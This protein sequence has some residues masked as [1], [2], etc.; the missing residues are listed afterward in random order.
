MTKL[1]KNLL[2]WKEIGEEGSALFGLVLAMLFFT[3]MGI[4]VVS[5]TANDSTSASGNLNGSE[6]FYVAEGG[7]Q[8]TI[9]N[10]LYGD[11]DWSDNVSPTDEPFGANSIT[12]G[13]GEF[14]VEY[15]NQ[16]GSSVDVRVT[17]RVGQAVRVVQQTVEPGGYP[18][19]A[20][21]NG[22]LSFQNTSGTMT[23]DVGVNGSYNDG[24][25]TIEGEIYEDEDIDIPDVDLAPYAAMTDTTV[26]GN[27]TI[28]SDYTGNLYVDG[29]VTIDGGVTYTGIL[30]ATGNITL[31]G[32]DI[33]INGTLVTEGNLT[34]NHRSD[35]YFLAQPVDG[36]QMPAIVADGNIE[37]N[38]G[39]NLNISGAVW[40]DGNIHMNHVDSINF[41]GSLISS[42][43]IQVEN[44]TGVEF[45]FAS[46]YMQGLPGF[47]PLPEAPDGTSSISVS[48]WQ[49]Q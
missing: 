44:S 15:L 1:A 2:G 36:V 14:W 4:T 46:E 37:L 5:L 49:A 22:N 39:D 43:T 27:Y 28:S 30:Y 8:H 9:Q 26:N 34:A 24:D 6:A 33:T 18:F 3:T 21:L 12:L 7:L 48:N 42:K 29:N 35:L 32:N 40:S 23:G 10:E 19:A 17:S 38:N 45:L 41:I 31:G 25:V 16:S 20:L 11:T 47:D 13:N